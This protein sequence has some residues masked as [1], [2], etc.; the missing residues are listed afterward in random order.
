MAVAFDSLRKRREVGE[1]SP[2]SQMGHGYACGDLR[3]V[4]KVL[5]GAHA[6]ER[7]C[8]EGV[9]QQLD[10]RVTGR[11]AVDPF[12]FSR[13]ENVDLLQRDRLGAAARG[14]A[15]RSFLETGV[16]PRQRADGVTDSGDR[17][18][19]ELQL[20]DSGVDERP[21][22]QHVHCGD[23]VCDDPMAAPVQRRR[24]GRLPSSRSS[25]EQNGAAVYVD[26]SRMK[27]EQAALAEQHGQDRPE[28]EESKHAWVDR[29]C[30]IDDDLT[31]A[32]YDKGANLTPM[33]VR[34]GVAHQHPA[35]CTH[36]FRG[37]TPAGTH[38][39]LDLSLRL[40]ALQ[41]G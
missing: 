18:G 9:P 31:A 34:I 29:G 17:V 7:V 35:L 20:G 36:G 32:S 22:G 12:V 26:G 5:R 33:E 41:L 14:N 13:R 19:P 11:E 38:A 27:D 1:R 10:Q 24:E 40:G 8:A 4:A 15:T 37:N 6:P 3:A 23:V 28:E 16:H 30:W 25:E 39:Q 2:Y 21:S